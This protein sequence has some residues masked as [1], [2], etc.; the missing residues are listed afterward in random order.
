MGTT[1]TRLEGYYWELLVAKEGPNVGDPFCQSFY[2]DGTYTHKKLEAH[3]C[4][5]LHIYKQQLWRR[6]QLLPCCN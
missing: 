3:H 2:E 5:G 4:H 6:A 1:G